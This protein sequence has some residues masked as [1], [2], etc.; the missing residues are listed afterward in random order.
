MASCAAWC[1]ALLTIL[2]CRFAVQIL[3]APHRSLYEILGVTPDATSREIRKV[4]SVHVTAACLALRLIDFDAFDSEDC[5]NL[6]DI[7]IR[8]TDVWH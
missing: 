6:T 4:S 8:H 2:L 3:S 1:A 7:L 5:F